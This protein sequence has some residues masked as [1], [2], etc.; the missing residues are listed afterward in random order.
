MENKSITAEPEKCCGCG[1]CKA[2]CPVR[3]ISMAEN[4][5]GFVMPQIDHT[6]CINCGKCSRVCAFSSPEKYISKDLPIKAYAAALKDDAVLKKSASGG[7]FAGTACHILDEGGVVFGA[8]MDKQFNVKHIGISSKSKLHFLQGSK[9]TQSDTSGVFASIKKQL[10]SGKKVLFSG[11]PCQVA[12]LKAF[13][14]KNQ[15]N[16]YTID[17]VCHGVGS[18]KMFKEDIEYL[19]GK[20]KSVVKAVSFRSKRKGWGTGG[21]LVLE[22]K[23][24]DYSPINSPYYYY[25]LDSSIFRDSC[26]YCPYATNRRVGDITIGDFWRIET[27]FKKIDIDTNKGVSC[28][29][30][31]TEKGKKLVGMLQ[32]GFK[33]IEADFE[34]IAMRNGNL[35]H[36][37]IINPNRGI[38]LHKYLNNGYKGI[39]NYFKKNTRKAR[40]KSRIKSIIPKRVKKHI[41]TIIM[42]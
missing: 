28:L 23:I 25:Y 7:V 35:T 22:D 1:A 10:E 5:F 17:L 31:N 36:A 8:A 27:L 18:N 24:K 19:R 41:K 30:V 3:A 20:Y 38:V 14:G 4:E 34:E 13:L 15:D 9:Y 21:D 42:K 12:A 40:L 16:L 11:T 26:Y 32:D 33:L 29:I 2:A 37:S 6:L 39:Y